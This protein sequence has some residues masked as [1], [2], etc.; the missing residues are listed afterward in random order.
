MPL[1][2]FLLL[3]LLGSGSGLQLWEIRED[4]SKEAPDPLLVRGRR[5]V[6]ED[7]EDDIYDY[8]GTDP[9]EMLFTTIPGPVGLTSKLLAEMATLG[10]KGS[11]TPTD[12]P[13][14]ATGASISLD[15]TGMA[16]GNLSM[17][18]TQGVPVTLDPLSKEQVTASPPITEFPSTEGAPFT[19]LATIEVLSMGPPDTEAMT[20]QP[21]ATE[22]LATEPKATEVLS[23][24]PAATEAL[25]TE[26]AV[27][28]ALATQ[29]KA[30]E[31]LSSEPPDT[32]ALTTQ[33]AATEV[34][35]TQPE[36]TEALS[37]GPAA[38]EA[39]TTQP[40]ATE[41]LSTGPEATDALSTEH[42]ATEAL[43]TD[44]AT[45]KVPPTGPVT[46]WR[47]T[48]ALLVPSDPHNSTAMAV[49]N[50]SDGFI[51][52]WKDQQGLS[53]K[54]PVAP[55]AMEAPDR[56]PVKQCLLAI[57]ILA[58]VATVFLVC[59]VV[60]AVRLS[61][62]NHMY[63]VRNY[64]PT[65]MVCISSLLPEGGEA[66][67]ATANGDLPHAKSQ[68]PKAGPGEGREGDDLTLQS[69]LP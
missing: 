42:T 38:T 14:A 15:A 68:D 48:M 17:E 40:V 18:P 9:P 13:Q 69:F 36:A 20:T 58:L 12:T 60:L 57:L 41:A 43:S 26:P 35:A 54:S 33:P 62:K 51:R 56:I 47:L 55:T 64:S 21:P 30:T 28:E 16:M 3:V 45:M 11:G 49:V 19:E 4:G 8:M 59:T 1:R 23:M 63:P 2:V 67:G 53:P 31:A 46:T 37:T 52:Q 22:V 7:A 65:E 24:G 29:P 10:R 66:P 61:R 25:A 27:T 32:E 5:E 50:S 39:L 34:L 6:R 44:P